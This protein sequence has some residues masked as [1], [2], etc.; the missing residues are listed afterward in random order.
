MCTSGGDSRTPR[1]TLGSSPSNRI[2]MAAG[3]LI[4]QQRGVIRG[5]SN[6]G[7]FSLPKPTSVHQMRHKTGHYFALRFDA[8]IATQEAVRRV[9]ANDPRMIRYSSVKLGD[10]KLTTLSK[11]GADGARGPEGW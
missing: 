11:F 8:S 2:V 9:L 4:L 6:W 7:V 3:N 10:G 5:V 1:L